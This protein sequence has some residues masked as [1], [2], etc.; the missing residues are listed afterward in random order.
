MN[1]TQA[2]ISGTAGVSLTMS[3]IWGGPAAYATALLPVVVYFIAAGS[4]Q[5]DISTDGDE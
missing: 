3:A 5:V 1:Q 2:F 4:L